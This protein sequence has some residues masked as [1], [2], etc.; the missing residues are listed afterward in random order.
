MFFYIYSHKIFFWLF[1]LV[2]GLQIIFWLKTERIRHNYDIVP[3]APS[4]Q[5]MNGASFGDKEFLFRIMATNL[6]NFGDIFAG[7]KSYKDYDYNRLYDW[8]TSLDSLNSQSRLV[9]SV[10]SYLF[11][12]TPKK[13]DIYFVLKYLDEHSSVN[14]DKNWWWLFQAVFIAKKDLNDLDKALYFA[15]KL[16]QNNATEAPIWTKQ[17]PAFIS[18][19]MGDN[20]MAFKIIKNLI[21]E[22]ESGKRVISAEEM[23]FMRHFI[24]ERLNKLKKQKFDANK[25]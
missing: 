12:Q 9:P 10:A 17:M 21:N 16:S 8:M 24:N 11:A 18:E 6:Q 25:C 22:S 3:P 15:N 20:C 5:F 1:L 2:F 4:K 7:F 19:K 14:I 23:N 13:D